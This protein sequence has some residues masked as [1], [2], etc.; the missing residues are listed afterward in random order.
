MLRVNQ[1]DFL[2]KRERVYTVYKNQ[3]EFFPLIG[4][5]SADIIRHQGWN[6]HGATVINTLMESTASE[7][8]FC[9]YNGRK[10]SIE[11]EA[12]RKAVIDICHPLNGQITMKV[13]LNSGA[14]YSRL[15]QFTNTPQFPIGLENRNPMWQ[16]VLLQYE[17]E[18]FWYSDH[19]ITED[20]VNVTPLFQFPFTMSTTAPVVFG[21]MLPNKIVYNTGQVEAPLTIQIINAC[22]NPL[23][24]N[25]T[26][27][28]FIKFKNLTMY[29]QDSL[30]IQTGYGK[31]SVTLNGY[32]VFDKLDYTTTFFNLA[33]GENEIEFSDDTVGT[34]SAKIFVTYRNLYITI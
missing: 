4:G 32:N 31:K 25:K 5:D 17:A 13:T 7:L 30:L 15:I 8:S 34:T 3:I 26:T 22:I 1:I 9:L 16:K 2:D 20:F 10:S 21:N 19:E 14:V 23:I 6:Q 12:Q 11:I 29:Y 27:G 33:L 24:L 28:E 18:P